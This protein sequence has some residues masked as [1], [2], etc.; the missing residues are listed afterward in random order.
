MLSILTPLLLAGVASAAT[1]SSF[2]PESSNDLFVA[3]GTTLALNGVL[4]PKNCTVPP[5]LLNEPSLTK[6]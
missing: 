5:S 6:L 2:S 3:F 4:L 1:P